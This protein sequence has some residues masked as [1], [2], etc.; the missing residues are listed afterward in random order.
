[1]KFLILSLLVTFTSLSGCCTTGAKSEVPA[2]DEVPFNRL[3][4]REPRLNLQN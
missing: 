2:K 3:E 1:M 4:P